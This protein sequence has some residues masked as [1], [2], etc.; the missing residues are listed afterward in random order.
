MTVTEFVPSGNQDLRKKSHSVFERFSRL[1]KKSCTMTKHILS[2][3]NS[4][5]NVLDNS[6][7]I[8]SSAFASE[9]ISY[10]CNIGVSF[11]LLTSVF[12]AKANQKPVRECGF[13]PF[14]HLSLT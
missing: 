4:C 6:F 14:T 9:T 13:S 2:F 3:S 5:M 10:C 7:D 8:E 11:D 1:W 12:S